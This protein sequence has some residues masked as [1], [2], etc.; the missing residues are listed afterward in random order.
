MEFYKKK[1]HFH[2]YVQIIEY[3]SITNEKSNIKYESI[4]DNK[5]INKH[6]RSKKINYLNKKSNIIF[7]NCD[8]FF[9]DTLIN[10]KIINFIIIFII[11]FNILFNI[12][13]I[14]FK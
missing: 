6:K 14:I 11:I 13:N 10:I 3:N 12:F 2:N 7:I 8:Y 5:I 4:I 1:I 9:T